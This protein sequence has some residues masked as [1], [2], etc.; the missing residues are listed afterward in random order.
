[1]TRLGARGVRVFSQSG[2]SG[3][4]IEYLRPHSMENRGPLRFISVGR[5]LHWKGFHLGLRAF[6]KADLPREIEYW[7]LGDGPERGN[8][9]ALVRELGIEDRVVF[10]GALPREETLAKLK[11]CDVLIHPSLH[12]SGGLVCL[13]AMAAGCPVICLR[14]GG[15]D[16]LL[17]E[18]AGLKVPAQTPEQAERDLSKALARMARDPVLRIRMSKAARARVNEVFDWEAKGRVWQEFYEEALNSTAGCRP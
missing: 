2:L 18:E 10:W 5:L 1:M 12:D 9:E 15:P 17:T 3:E 13:E 4:E 16:V 11:E 8:L 7:I 6:A 14:L